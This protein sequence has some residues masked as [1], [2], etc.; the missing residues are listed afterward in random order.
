MDAIYPPQ[1]AACHQVVA[2]H[3]Q[4]C[5]KCWSQATFIQPPYCACCGA[6]FEYDH[7]DGSICVS[8]LANRPAYSQARA[9]MIY[10]D[11]ARTLVL[12][13]K[14]GDRL[15]PALSYAQMMARAGA[16]II[17]SADVIVPV[18]LHWTRLFKRR[19]N[20]SAILGQH[21][22]L[23]ANKTHL[24]DGLVR[25]KRTPPQAFMKRAERLRNVRNAFDVHPKHG[26]AIRGKT[27]LIIDDVLT[28][29]ATV[30]NCTQSLYKA[31]ADTVNV[32]TLARA[33]WP[34]VNAR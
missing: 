16:D 14:H 3:G 28:T 11:I 31:G 34:G 32:L 10:D 30:E 29:G 2:Q 1:C 8:C 6:P 22:A 27:I 9:A 5:A 4:L 15:G 24:P 7:G 17:E 20:Q 13:F 19:Y 23:L 12:S 18:P 26:D 25:R 21:I 33:R